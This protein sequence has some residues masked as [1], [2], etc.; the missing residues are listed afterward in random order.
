MI[1]LFILLLQITLTKSGVTPLSQCKTG[2]ATFYDTYASENVACKL[3][4]NYPSN[5]YR[6]APNE[7]LFLQSNQCGI[8]YEATG[9]IGSVIVMVSDLCPNTPENAGN[10]DG[11][12]D[13]FDIGENAFPLICSAKSGKCDISYR[14]VA[15]NVEGNVKLF[16]TTGV[17]QWWL[18][19]YARNYVIGLKSVKIT[20]GQTTRDMKR[21][22]S[23]QWTYQTVSGEVITTPVKV[24]FT[25]I[26]G[27][28]ATIIM[29]DIQSSK[30]Y[31]GQNQFK[32]P[33][34]TFF[35]PENLQKVTLPS[36]YEECCSIP[37]N[38]MI[39][40]DSIQSFWNVGYGQY[41]NDQTV[42]KEGTS[43]MKFTWK[44]WEGMNINVASHY[45]TK[46]MYK[47]IQM[48]VKANK[49]GKINVWHLKNDGKKKQI[50]VTTEWTLQTILFNDLSFA[51]NYFEGF[52]I[53]HISDTTIDYY[54]D[55]IK[56]IKQ[57]SVC[58]QYCS[59]HKSECKVISTNG[60]NNNG[61]G[62]NTNNNTN[63]N[64]NTNNGNNSNSSNTNN[65]TNNNNT[66]NTN[67]KPSDKN[68]STL[69]S[70]L[71]MI[72]VTFILI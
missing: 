35:N 62:G 57:D 6:V 64:T 42:K 19:F 9:E 26:A 22:N 72:I 49:N 51:T 12:H 70:L 29:N 10:C 34:K 54:F 24:T 60:N 68:K 1:L 32:I 5:I 15:C 47:G 45:I 28:E 25:S 66:N 31:I 23:N 38:T 33:E 41:T 53:Q 50:S 27:D 44:Q 11:G 2:K 46:S 37:D 55:E 58:Y 43:S 59:D 39:Y 67:N 14:M 63:N 71:L 8:C 61:N 13:H 16:T 36:T 7:K 56:L 20:F 18:G 21:S 48:F 69:V 52:E 65:T 17:S 4:N 40:H 30:E 3:G